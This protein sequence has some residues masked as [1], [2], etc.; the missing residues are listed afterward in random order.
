MGEFKWGGGGGTLQ[1]S[2]NELTWLST[3]QMCQ[4]KLPQIWFP[5][6]DY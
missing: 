2:S 1:A 3:L 4:K 6:S 5:N